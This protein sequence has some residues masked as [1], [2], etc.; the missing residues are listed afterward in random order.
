MTSQ[1]VADAIKTQL[2]VTL[3]R[4]QIGL[5]EPIKR[6]GRFLCRLD[7]HREVDAR[8]TVEV[9]DPNAPVETLPRLKRRRSSPEA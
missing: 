8:I 6:L 1:D 2:G 9:Y 7:L 3:E 4:K 5:A